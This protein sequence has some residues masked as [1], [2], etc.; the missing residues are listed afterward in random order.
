MEVDSDEADGSERREG[1]SEGEVSSR[2]RKCRRWMEWEMEWEWEWEWECKVCKHCIVRC[3]VLRY[4]RTAWLA[5]VNLG[6]LGI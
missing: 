2:V 1:E 4:G 5:C 6:Q 3:T